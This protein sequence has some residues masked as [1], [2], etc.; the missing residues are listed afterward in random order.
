M[1]TAALIIGIEGWDKFTLPLIESIETHEPDCQIVVIDNASQE[2]YPRRP[3]IHRTE[4][5]CY[6]AAINRA[7]SFAPDADWLIVLS[8]DVLC[9]GPFADVLADLPDTVVAGPELCRIQAW[10]FIM[11][12]CV[13]IPR[14]V[15][16]AVGGWDE[17]YIVSSWEDVDFSVSALEMGYNIRQ[18]NTLPFVHLDQ[19]QRLGLPEFQG[20][21]EKNRA[22]FEKKHGVVYV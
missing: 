16:E 5:L 13:C 3:Y 11:G 15:W 17:K 6:A 18:T 21:H 12:W 1:K 7:A 22:Y 9:F 19:R 2:P 8:N 4:R 14:L 20:T 10:R